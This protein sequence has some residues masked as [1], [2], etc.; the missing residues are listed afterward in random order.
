[1]N[2]ATL[3]GQA[4]Q[5]ERALAAELGLRACGH[6]WHTQRDAWMRLAMEAAVCAGSLAKLAR[7]WSLMSQFEVGEIAEATHG[8]TSS[9]MPHKRNAVRCM[10]ALAQA[11]P[12]PG[13]AA[14]LLGSM[15]Q[16][17]ERA[18][19]EWQAELAA[20]AP[21]WRHVHGAAAALRLAAQGLQVDPARMQAHIDDLHQ[22]IFSEACAHALAPIV[23]P[24]AAQDTVERLA[25]Q[26]LARHQPLSVLLQHWLQDTCGA[27]RA[28]A[29]QAALSAAIDPMRAVQASAAGCA[30]LLQTLGTASRPS[31]IQESRHV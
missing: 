25:P 30:A 9:A 26:A 27:D 1:G 24:D 4:A 16:A 8:K 14:T 12:V 23:G 29:A 11:Q 22:V 2:R 17:H 20:W 18:M 15:A 13:L 6:A 21:L 28:Q 31:S 7:D 10:Q 19:G 5:V 3:G